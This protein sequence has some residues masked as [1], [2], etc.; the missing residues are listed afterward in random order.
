[1]HR[2]SSASVTLL[3]QSPCIARS[4]GKLPIL[5]NIN[6]VFENNYPSLMGIFLYFHI[7]LCIFVFVGIFV[8]YP[9]VDVGHINSWAEWCGHYVQPPSF[10][11]CIFSYLY[12]C[13]CVL[14]VLYLCV[15]Q[16]TV[17]IIT[18]K[19]AGVVIIAVTTLCPHAP[20]SNT[21]WLLVSLR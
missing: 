1:M 16:W 5:F 20:G 13:I 10:C 19:Q 6:F 4:Q 12:F 17:V 9:A 18:V 21:N 2:V 11:I 14:V 8:L 7:V 3:L 15:Q